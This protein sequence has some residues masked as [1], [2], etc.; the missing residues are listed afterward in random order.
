M[1]RWRGAD[2]DA[3]L[4]RLRHL[5]HQAVERED[6]VRPI[7]DAQLTAHV[8][9]RRLQRLHLLEQRRQIDHHAVADHRH[10]AAP[11]NSARDQ[12]QYEFPV[13]DEHGMAGVVPALIARH[14]IEAL[15]QQ[16]DHF[17][18]CPRRP[19]ARQ[20]RSHFPLIHPSIPQKLRTQE[21]RAHVRLSTPQ[22]V[23]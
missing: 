1:P 6:H 21:H 15:G 12:L 4:P 23:S 9:A 13:A 11:Q 3:I 17:A 10:H 7:A 8:D 16:I 19:T 14:D 20:E 5:L 18:L 22:P 2:G